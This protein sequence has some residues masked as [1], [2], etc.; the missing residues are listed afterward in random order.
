MHSFR[1][2]FEDDPGCD[3]KQPKYV[4]RKYDIL[5]RKSDNEEEDL[6]EDSRR[7]LRA[8]EAYEI[9]REINDDTISLLGLDPQ[10]SRPGF[11]IIKKLIV[12]PPS[13]RPSI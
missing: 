1:C 13:V 5:I 9:L 7:I 12:V 4:L 11:M 6:D 3:F 10:N 8:S 2:G